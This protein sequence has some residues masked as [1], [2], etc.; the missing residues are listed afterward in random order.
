MKL[1][2]PPISPVSGCNVDADEVAFFS[3]SED[4]A[5]EDDDCDALATE[6]E[7]EPRE[8]APLAW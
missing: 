3:F 1:I 8:M 7:E 2:S 5:V 4:V 6:R